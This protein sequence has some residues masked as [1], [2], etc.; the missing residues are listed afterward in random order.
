MPGTAA[1]SSQFVTPRGDS[2]IATTSVSSF[3]MRAAS[4]TGIVA[5]PSCCSPPPIERLPTGGKRQ[6]FAARR[7]SSAVSMWGK[8]I[9]CAP[10]SS[11]REASQCSSPAT[12]T[13][14]VMPTASEAAAICAAVSPSMELCSQSMKSQ[15]KPAVFAIWAMSTVRAWRSPRPMASLPARSW[16]SAWLG[17]VLMRT[18]LSVRILGAFGSGKITA[19]TPA[20]GRYVALSVIALT[21]ALAYGIWYAYS[22]ILVALLNEFGWSRSVLAGAFSVFTLVHGAVN[23]VIG[24]LCARLKP[25]RVMAA[26]G[27]A[28]GLALYADSFIATPAQLYLGFGVLTALAVAAAGWIPALV[29]VQREF[30]DRV[31][32]AMGIASAGVG[33]GMLIVVPLAQLLIDAF[34]WRTAFQVLG[35]L[36][37]LW[38]VPSSMWLMRAPRGAAAVPAHAVAAR[39]KPA[40]HAMTLAEASRTEPFWLLVAA[41]FF[42]NLCSQTLHVHQVAYL[43]DHGLAAMVAASVVSVVGLA[44]IVGKTGGGWLSDRVEREVVYVAGIGILAASAVVLLAL[45][46]A[47][48]RWGAYGYAVL[49]GVGYSVTASITP[50]MVSDRFSGTHFGAIVGIGLVGAAVGSALGPWLAGMAYDATGSYTL[51]FMIAAACGVAAGAAGWR[52]RTLRRSKSHDSAGMRGMTR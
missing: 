23:P 2:I 47:P 38:I 46:A 37:V 48:T 52:A 3:T 25:L 17:T 6:A 49:L 13:T 7:A 26:G 9:P 41:F 18:S 14:G 42:G 33:V 35:I 10:L 5:K 36:S 8:T 15:S 1:I 28:M 11:I 50:A 44:S 31:G 27:V 40:S 12:R 22:V 51:P 19:L 39:L 29:H 24:A 20:S 21:L 45:G 30:Q 43:V 4:P 34:G 16:R 32:L